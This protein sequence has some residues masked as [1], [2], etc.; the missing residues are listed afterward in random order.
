MLTVFVS[1]FPGKRLI[2]VRTAEKNEVKIDIGLKYVFILW[3]GLFRR[4]CETIEM[5]KKIS[6]FKFILGNEGV[7]VRVKFY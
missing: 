2:D 4:K 1:V 7:T 5:K 3:F 6:R